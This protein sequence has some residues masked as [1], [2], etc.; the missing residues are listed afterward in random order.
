M[1]AKTGLFP[2]LLLMLVVGCGT[3]PAET[4]T[5]AGIPI[6]AFTPLA[7]DDIARFVPVLPELAGHISHHGRAFG[8]ETSV[9]QKSGKLVSA[10]IE[11]LG[12]T[13]G[14]DSI[15]A[16]HGLDWPFCRA[17]LWRLLV[18][19]WA[20]GLEELREA[21]ID[22]QDVVRREPSP[23]RAKALRQRLAEMR[24]T[25]KQVPAANIAVFERHYRELTV[26]L[27]LLWEY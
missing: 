17:M 27:R 8:E 23:T 18:C 3:G 10:A 15:A 13:P 1:K 22:I 21:G 5:E 19:S 9:R 7:E 25:A 20:I 4:E 26:F 16:A 11:R 24:A 12:A 6:I 2:T 14:V